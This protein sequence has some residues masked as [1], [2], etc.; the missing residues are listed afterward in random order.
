MRCRSRG[1][2]RRC[3]RSASRESRASA[4]PVVGSM[5]L[6][7]EGVVLRSQVL[8][9]VQNA[10]EIAQIARP[11]PRHDDLRRWTSLCFVVGNRVLDRSP[12]IKYSYLP[13][14]AFRMQHY[15]RRRPSSARPLLHPSAQPKFP[16]AQLVRAGHEVRSMLQWRHPTPPAREAGII[17]A[18]WRYLRA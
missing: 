3:T 10:P 1:S 17:S 15:P 12:T 14:S 11:Q 8:A 18:T 7:R 4:C 16:D 2:G 6:S 13:G 5:L 9:P